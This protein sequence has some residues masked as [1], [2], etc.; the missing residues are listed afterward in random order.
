MG[1]WCNILH[2]AD[3]NKEEDIVKYCFD[4]VYNL[5]NYHEM[6]ARVIGNKI[7]GVGTANKIVSYLQ[8]NC[9][10]TTIVESGLDAL[11]KM[12]IVDTHRKEAINSNIPKCLEEISVTQ[13][14]SENIF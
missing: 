1:L 2:N 5:M 9:L 8:R 10:A 7:N 3:K 4:I 12:F 6:E 14:W 13:S 11:E